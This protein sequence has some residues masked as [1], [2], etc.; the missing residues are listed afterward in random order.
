MS[1]AQKYARF[2]AYSTGVLMIGALY[3][4]ATYNWYLY[5]EVVS[6]YALFAW[7]FFTITVANIG[8]FLSRRYLRKADSFEWA[9]Y[10]LS[11]LFLIPVFVQL[12]VRPESGLIENRPIFFAVM[13]LSALVGA[14][15]AVNKRKKQKGATK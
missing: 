11:L 2:F 7:L 1:D 4:V 3:Y 10:V 14:L 8:F 5:I 13:T 12:I 9:A 15:I 6:I